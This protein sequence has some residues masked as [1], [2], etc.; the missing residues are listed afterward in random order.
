MV[1]NY[2]YQTMDN[3][4]WCYRLGVS[5]D[6]DEKL[7]MKLRLDENHTCPDCLE[8]F[9]DCQSLVHHRSQVCGLD[10]MYECEKCHRRFKNDYNLKAHGVRCS[11]QKLNTSEKDTWYK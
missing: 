4:C 8:I 2:N 3:K 10:L 5:D 7:F 6:L 9:N 1:I 11:K